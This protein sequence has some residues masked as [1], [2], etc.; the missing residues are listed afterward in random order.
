MAS[1]PAERLYVVYEAYSK[2]YG[3]RAQDWKDAR[4][5][6]QTDT[7]FR[8]VESLEALYLKAAKQALDTNAQAVENAFEAAKAA[9]R[10]INDAY[11]EA[12]DIVDK[13]KLVGSV[14]SKVGDL[15]RKAGGK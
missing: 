15:I 6:A 14:V 12:K 13:I 9:Q 7:I 11:Q 10:E 8:N 2:A 4:T 3:R 1:T 5:N